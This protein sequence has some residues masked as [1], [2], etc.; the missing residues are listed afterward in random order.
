[1]RNAPVSNDHP[2]VQIG[3]LRADERREGMRGAEV[4]DRIRGVLQLRASA[5]IRDAV[6]LPFAVHGWGE[7]DE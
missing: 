4:E 5:G 7:T 3:W 6:R 2:I 1:M